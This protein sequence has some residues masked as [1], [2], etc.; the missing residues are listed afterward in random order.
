MSGNELCRLCLK[1]LNQ[2][3]KFHEITEEIREEFT[4]VTQMELILTESH[5]NTICE[6]CLR[7]LLLASAV[8]LQFIENQQKFYREND[9]EEMIHLEPDINVSTG[10]D[11]SINFVNVMT[12][13]QEPEDPVNEKKTKNSP[14]KNEKSMLKIQNVKSMKKLECD[15][16]NKFY[17]TLIK[18]N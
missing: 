2:N 13:K 8:K 17:S 3:E 11:S 5:S 7:S 16:C 4:N 1:D 10:F 12:I 9:F 6:L 18:K 14:K 15:L